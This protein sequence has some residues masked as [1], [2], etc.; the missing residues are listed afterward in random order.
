MAKKTFGFIAKD[1]AAL[2]Y[3][4]VPIIRGEKRPAV[5]KWQA[6]GWE[7]HTQQFETNYTGL[8]TRFNPG[9]DIDVSDEELV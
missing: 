2:G 7:E 9:V 8:L 6:G 1:L 5:D 3:E 4:P